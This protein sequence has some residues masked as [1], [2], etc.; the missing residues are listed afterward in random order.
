MWTPLLRRKAG[1]QVGKLAVTRSYVVIGAFKLA[2][3]MSLTRTSQKFLRISCSF[4]DGLFERIACNLEG[5]FPLRYPL[6]GE[7]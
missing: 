7:L 5:K 3:E 1:V 4:L 6:I 2:T